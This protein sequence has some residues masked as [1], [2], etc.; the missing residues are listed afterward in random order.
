MTGKTLN[1]KIRDW[2]DWFDKWCAVGNYQ[3]TGDDPIPEP[4]KHPVADH[5]YNKDKIAW[6]EKQGIF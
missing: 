2:D 1:Q 4:E 6:L 5:E 3:Q